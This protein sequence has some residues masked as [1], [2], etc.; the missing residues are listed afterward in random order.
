M[1]CYMYHRYLTFSHW[2]G[3]T[4][5]TSSYEF[6]GSCVFD[7][8]LPE[9]L[10]LRPMNLIKGKP[11]PEVTAAILP[12]SLGNIHSFALVYST[13]L[14]VSV[15]GTDSIVLTLDTFLGSVLCVIPSGEPESLCSAWMLLLRHSPDFPREHPH[16]TNINPII[17]NAYNPSSYLRIQQKS[18]NI[19]HVPIGCG[20]RHPL[21]T[22]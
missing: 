5:Y 6:A 19:N 11:Y 1:Y 14:P 3:V 2:S 10:S 16:S 17:C 18:W 22:D 8:Q 15:Y 4:P 20:F 12:S 13:W 7:K 9:N 21:R